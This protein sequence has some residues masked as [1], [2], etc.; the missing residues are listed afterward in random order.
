[1]RTSAS[2][3]DVRCNG[4]IRRC[5]VLGAGP[6]QEALLDAGRQVVCLDTWRHWLRVVKLLQG[7]AEVLQATASGLLL[8]AMAGILAQL[9]L[10]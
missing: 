3:V 5:R 8:P 10:P 4:G 2:Q 7:A 1:M 6:N 9:A